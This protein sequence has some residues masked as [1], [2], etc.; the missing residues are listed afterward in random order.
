MP[1][2]LR[3]GPL[4]LTVLLDGE[5]PMDEPREVL[6]PDATSHQW[7]DADRYDPATY[8]DGRWWLFF[9]C[10]AIRTNDDRVILVDTGI[11]SASAPSRGWAPVPGR[12]PDELGAAGIGP[13]EI[14]TVVLTHLH[15]DHIGWSIRDD[16][17]PYFRNARYVLQRREIETI[18]ATAPQLAE[19]LLAPLRAAG[20]LVA[21]DPMTE[22]AVG[23]TAVATPGHTPGHQ[24]VLLGDDVLIAG[25]LLVH[26]VQLLHP[27]LRYHHEADPDAARVSRVEFLER[28]RSRGGL[29][30]T[31]H[32]G[33]PVVR[34]GA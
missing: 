16:G 11:G 27:D 19:W 34:F 9:R 29:L 31:P 1:F 7:A 28:L 12:L 15:S 13:D 14:D 23:V 8:R 10:F 25:D 6:F 32:L 26:A 2:T 21:A 4:T 22:L 5:G 30:V 3:L 20:Q 24:S 18:D 33:E 17:T